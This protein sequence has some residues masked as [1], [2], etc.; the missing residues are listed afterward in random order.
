MIE[1]VLDASAVLA[2]LNQEAG[3][4]AVAGYL[5]AAA[6]SAVNLAEVISRLSDRGLDPE[7]CHEVVSK[8][9]LRVVAFDEASAFAAGGLRASARDAGLSLGDRA[10]LGL[11]RA[12]RCAAVT[13]DRTWMRLNLGIDVRLIRE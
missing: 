10:C 4:D 8:L 12:S 1:V 6:I 2:F 7:Q 5:G 13:A 11:A 3:A 9:G